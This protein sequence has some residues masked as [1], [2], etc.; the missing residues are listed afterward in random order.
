MKKKIVF[1]KRA[2][3]ILLFALPCL[4]ISAFVIMVY[5][6]RLDAV[7]LIHEKENIVMAME[8]LSKFCVCL[9]VGAILTDIAERKGKKTDI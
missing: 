6:I 4:V 1:G 2:S 3:K 7:S 5:V 9:T 8:F